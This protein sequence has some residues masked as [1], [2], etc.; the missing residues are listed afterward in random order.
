MSNRNDDLLTAFCVERFITLETAKKCRLQYL[1]PA[2]HA[3]AMGAPEIKHPAIALPFINIHGKSTGL[4]RTRPLV[5]DGREA[6]KRPKYRQNIFP[7]GQLYFPQIIDWERVASDPNEVVILVNGEFK[8][9]RQCQRG[10]N[11]I[12]VPNGTDYFP[13]DPHEVGKGAVEV[14]CLQPFEAHGSNFW[15]ALDRLRSR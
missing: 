14:H 3:A 13:G 11:T 1:S 5:K 15:L 8:A 2:E 10:Y 6:R 9:I 12:G 7:I 4:V